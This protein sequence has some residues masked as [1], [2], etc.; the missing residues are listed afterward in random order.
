MELVGSRREDA[1]RHRIELLSSVLDDSPEP[2]VVV[3]RDGRLGYANPACE[4][5]FGSP[6][7][8][9]VGQAIHDFVDAEGT[10]GAPGPT[11]CVLRGHFELR[12]RDG[13]LRWVSYS[14]SPLRGDAAGGVVVYLRD[15]T[16]RRRDELRWTRRHDD[17]EQTIRA[18]SHDLRSPLVAV[19]GFSRLLRDDFGD[20]LGER[21]RHYVDRIREAGRTMEALIRELLDFARIGHSGEQ[22]ALVDPCEVLRQIHGELKPKLDALGVEISMPEEPPL[23]LC[24]RTRLYQL[25]SNLIGNAL[26]HMGPCE[27]PRIAVEISEEGEWSRVRVGDN[28][29]GIEPDERERVFEVFHTIPR[30]DGRRG[31]G[32]G[33][34]IVKKIAELHG[35]RV[36]V[37]G[38]PGTGATFCVLLPRP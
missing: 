27:S 11:T 38:E 7:R 18:V 4:A 12:R 20:H 1:D 19:L 13:E 25:L 32:I 33:L 34:A 8:T 37:E 21:G 5:L 22:R 29:R 15:D 17:L 16:Q 30:E 6:C 28:G 23:L 31:T 35:G 26:D 3:G 2:V 14:A 36:W 10:G 9:L 24:D